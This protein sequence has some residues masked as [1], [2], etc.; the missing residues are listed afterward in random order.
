MC[1]AIIIEPINRQSAPWL[2]LN[3]SGGSSR[4]RR[5]IAYQEI[6]E[7]YGGAVGHDEHAL[8]WYEQR[9]HH[10]ERSA[11]AFSLEDER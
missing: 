6:V 11:I 10:L 9:K 2:H 4:A 5:L 7:W 8:S 3:E 1:A